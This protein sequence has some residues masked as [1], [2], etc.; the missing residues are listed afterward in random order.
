MEQERVMLL[1]NCGLITQF[2]S[3]DPKQMQF[4]DKLQNVIITP[5]RQVSP[6]L[7]PMVRMVSPLQV[8]LWTSILLEI[9]CPFMKKVGI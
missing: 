2:S 4:L 3:L 7:R 1:L 6:L 9:Q 5:Q 8:A